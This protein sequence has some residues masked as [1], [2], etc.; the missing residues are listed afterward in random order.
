MNTDN[1]Y[2]T[3]NDKTAFWI[4]GYHDN[5]EGTVLLYDYRKYLEKLEDIFSNIVPVLDY[6]KIRYLNCI[7]KSGHWYGNALVYITNIDKCPEGFTDLGD[8]FNDMW[9]F[10]RN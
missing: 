4:A 9:D 7:E 1:C 8:N 6:S 10:I 5:K 3:S 2:Y